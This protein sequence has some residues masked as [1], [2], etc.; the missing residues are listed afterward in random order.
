MFLA[1][2]ANTMA[3]T[4]ALMKLAKEMKPRPLTTRDC[5]AARVEA[6]AQRF[7][8]RTAVI[9]EGKTRTWQELNQH[10]NRYAAAFR[11]LGLQRG[12]AVSVLME[13]RIEFL[14]VVF[15]LNKLGIGTALIN[16]NL[17]GR[18]LIHCIGI[19]GSRKCIFGEEC[20]AA[21]ED[22]RHELELKAGED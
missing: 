20:L 9:F 16:T 13:N 2:V 6:T 19:T 5:F 18:P 21:V 1:D 22:A 10:A 14:V 3:Q 8:D 15:A 4:P 12:D 7:G 11:A 17:T